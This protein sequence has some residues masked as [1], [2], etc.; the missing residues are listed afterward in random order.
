MSYWR[1]QTP[2]GWLKGESDSDILYALTFCDDKPKVQYEN[3]TNGFTRNLQSYFEGK[4]TLVD[5]VSACAEES[6]FKAKVLKAC[7]EI[8]FGTT[9]SYSELAEKCGSSG[10][11]QAVGQ[12]M[13]NNVIP[14][15]IPC[16]RVIPKNGSLGGFNA[17]IERKKWL[18]EHES[19]YLSLQNR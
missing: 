13:K 11:A 8:P 12:I 19:Y 15:I 2:I 17:G 10:A 3:K 7:R 14:L 5:M 6:S 9:Q 1:L 18:L 16:H 4:N